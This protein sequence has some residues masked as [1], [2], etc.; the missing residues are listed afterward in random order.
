MTY[1]PQVD[2]L[3]RRSVGDVHLLFALHA[4]PVG[5]WGNRRERLVPFLHAAVPDQPFFEA[6]RPWE[7]LS[8]SQVVL[9]V[10]ARPAETTINGYNY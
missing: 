7:L 3:V 1:G 9:L 2:D 4:A 8:L 6:T 10:P 5:L